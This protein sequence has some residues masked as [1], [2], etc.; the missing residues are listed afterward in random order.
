[1]KLNVTGVVTAVHN[2]I[3]PTP[4]NKVRYTKYVPNRKLFIKI[5]SICNEI[6]ILIIIAYYYNAR[7]VARTY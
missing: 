7:I 1:M 2:K 3:S 6:I 4:P 5:L